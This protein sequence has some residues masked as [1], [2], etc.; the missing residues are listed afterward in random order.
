MSKN[1]SQIETRERRVA[2]PLKTLVP[3]IKDDLRQ[4]DDV[5]QQ[6]GMP[7]YIAAGEKL[8][9]ARAQLKAMTWGAW[10][11]KNF[12]LSQQTA[13]TY[14]KA[15]EKSNACV[16]FDTLKEARGDTRQFHQPTWTEPVRDVLKD[17]RTASFNLRKHDLS[18]AKE[19]DLERKL[20]LNL[21]DIGFKV[22]SVKLHP[23]KG[24]S[25]DAMQR[26]NRVRARLKGAA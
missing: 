1:N 11:T 12:H 22:L 2:R 8:I 23:D 15:A 26:L 21:I 6:A 9:E 24:G 7:Y 16:A 17:I 14:M 10:L 25:H 4:G 19:R 13:R 20:A 18:A 5:A 3:L